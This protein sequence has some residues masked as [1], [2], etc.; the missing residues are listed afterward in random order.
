MS[1]NPTTCDYGETTTLTYN[2][3]DIPVYIYITGDGAASDYEYTNI[4]VDEPFSSPTGKQ[5]NPNGPW[6]DLMSGSIDI[7]LQKVLDG[8]YQNLPPGNYLLNIA[9]IVN[10]EWIIIQTIDFDI[11]SIP[12]SLDENTMTLTHNAGINSKLPNPVYIQ[13]T[14]AP[15]ESPDYPIPVWS[16]E[17]KDENPPDEEKIITTPLWTTVTG[18]P[19]QIYLETP[20]T[21]TTLQYLTD[22]T[23]TLRTTDYL[24][25]YYETT[26][27][28]TKPTMSVVVQDGK[29]ILSVSN[30]P[31]HGYVSI[32]DDPEPNDD[33][34]NPVLDW[35][36]TYQTDNGT[37]PTTTLNHVWNWKFTRDPQTITLE[38]VNKS[39]GSSVDYTPGI[40][41]YVRLTD[42][43]KLY[44]WASFIMP[45]GHTG[46]TGTTGAT[47]STGATG[48]TGSTGATGNTGAT[49]PSDISLQWAKVFDNNKTLT[50]AG[51]Y[52][53]YHDSNSPPSQALEDITYRDLIN[54]AVIGK[55]N[56]HPTMILGGGTYNDD[57]YISDSN[58]NPIRLLTTNNNKI[59]SPDQ[60]R[61]PWRLSHYVRA[62]TD[63]T[64]NNTQSSLI[65][66]GYNTAAAYVYTASK[67]SNG[68][69]IT[70]IDM[71]TL[72]QTSNP[73]GYAGNMVPPL[74][75]LIDALVLKEIFIEDDIKAYSTQIKALN[76]NTVLSDLVI[77]LTAGNNSVYPLLH[78]RTEGGQQLGLG[79][80]A[81]ICTREFLCRP[82]FDVMLKYDNILSWTTYDPSYKTPLN[83]PTP[84]S[85]D[86]LIFQNWIQ[87]YKM[88]AFRGIDF[89]NYQ[90]WPTTHSQKYSACVKSDAYLT[91]VRIRDINVTV[92]DELSF[93]DNNQGEDDTYNYVLYTETGGTSGKDYKFPSYGTPGSVY[94][95]TDF[96]IY[97][98]PDKY[99]PGSMTA[100]ILSYMGIMFVGMNDYR[101][102]CKWH[103]MV[104]HLLFIQNGGSMYEWQDNNNLPKDYIAQL[105][106]TQ[107]PSAQGNYWIPP[108][109]VEGATTPTWS[110]S[111]YNV[112]QFPPEGPGTNR[113]NYWANRWNPYRGDS[114]AGWRWSLPSYC[115]G[116]SPVW[117]T[118]GKTSQADDNLFQGG[119]NRP[120]A[121][122]LNPMYSSYNQSGGLYSA[123]DADNNILQAYIL[124][125]LQ[126]TTKPTDL[127]S[128]DGAP[129]NSGFD[130]PVPPTTNGTQGDGVVHGYDCDVSD[131]WYNT[132][133]PITTTT[134]TDSGV[135]YASKVSGRWTNN[136]AVVGSG[137]NSA[138][139]DKIGY[140]I[141][142]DPTGNN[143]AG[144]WSYPTEKTKTATTDVRCT[145]WAYIAKSIQRT[146]ISQHGLAFN[147]NVGNFVNP[148]TSSLPPRYVT[149]GHSSEP[150]NKYKL[151]YIDPRLMQV[152]EKVTYDAANA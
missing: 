126:W 119:L 99:W 61:Q 91:N 136:P 82:N 97:G 20:D 67:D 28:V 19:Y 71:C 127:L 113:T 50:E 42:Y 17:Y 64:V 2:S 90:D 62:N 23:Y 27:P 36:E 10:S 85:A 125:S 103:R 122:V 106:T 37:G 9:K 46:G 53:A 44:K 110:V 1:L 63:G 138:V 33:E 78:S 12:Y 4:L 101:N 89:H 24:K 65:K 141:T 150:N 22:G 35:G 109:C 93:G 34:N 132:D 86:D 116:Y 118:G 5:I 88:A 51:L 43:R 6:G 76:N 8:R 58:T 145:S 40:E 48:N 134:G 21:P 13:L 123:T 146:M 142:Y 129:L 49:G 80:C 72:L 7:Y 18:Y 137:P 124:A 147:K 60:C 98:I 104:W 14:P 140:G 148:D 149:L 94:V 25:I 128:A 29:L 83:L 74:L 70:G 107:S 144:S 92:G 30:F 77:L 56:Y 139:T 133:K 69:L 100:E 41:Y 130:S 52:N 15:G 151:D 26:F 54:N 95:Y 81:F 59:N 79:G 96:P 121:E 38:P 73:Y 75:A 68:Y 45:A 57:Y 114:N 152:C 11:G 143:G 32:H 66:I 84:T 117:V 39:S 115:M 135:Y 16:V 131:F 111:E 3:G 47:G 105:N 31:Q 112:Y 55:T 102:F 108:Y 120:I 87:I